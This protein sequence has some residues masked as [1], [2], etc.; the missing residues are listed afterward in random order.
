VASVLNYVF[1]L[2]IARIFPLASY[3]EYMTAISYLMLLGVPLGAV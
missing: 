2:L 3:G 1:N